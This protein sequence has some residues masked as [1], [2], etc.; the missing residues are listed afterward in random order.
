M[1]LGGMNFA[2]WNVSFYKKRLYFCLIRLFIWLPFALLALRH[3]IYTS[4]NGLINGSHRKIENHNMHLWNVIGLC[5]RNFVVKSG[6]VAFR[7]L[8]ST[9]LTPL[10]SFYTSWKNQKIFG[11]LIFSGGIERDQWL[12]RIGI[13]DRLIEPSERV[14]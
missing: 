9:H 14:I 1:N 11:F 5:V 12:G 3:I 13:S 2:F 10:A 4:E 7:P 8:I 6:S